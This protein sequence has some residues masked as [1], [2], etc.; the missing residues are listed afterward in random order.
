MLSWCFNPTIDAI[1]KCNVFKVAIVV[2]A[3]ALEIVLKNKT[4]RKSNKQ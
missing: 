4:D 3:Y 2:A 1:T